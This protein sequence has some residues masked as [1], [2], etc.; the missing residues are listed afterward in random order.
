MKTSD[1]RRPNM[2]KI[3]LRIDEEDKKV[4]EKIAE[5][6][7]LSIS[8]LVRRAIKEYIKKIKEN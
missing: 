3:S 1:E 5:E 6:Q 7:D 8:Q 2:A 4:L